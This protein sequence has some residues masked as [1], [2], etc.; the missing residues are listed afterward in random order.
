MTISSTTNRVSY[1]GDAVTVA[2]AFPY[3]FLVDADITV[4]L[5]VDSTAVETTQT[6]TT[7]YTLTGAGGASGGTVT[8][9]TAPAVGETLVILRN[10]AQTQ[11]LDLTEN[12]SL[13]AESVEQAIDRLTIIAQRLQDLMDRA[14]TLSDGSAASSLSLPTPVAGSAIG[15][16]ADE[17]T[18]VNL[19]DI[20]GTT[21]SAFGE[22]LIDDANAAAARTTLD[23]SQELDSLTALTAPALDDL[24]HLRDVSGTPANKKMA[25][26][27]ILGLTNRVGLYNLALSTGADATQLKLSGGAGAALSATNPGY[28][29]IESNTAGTLTTFRVTADITIDLTGADWGRSGYGDFTDVLLAFYVI[30][31]GSGTFKIGIGM[32]P[33]L[34]TINDTDTSI[35]AS[36]IDAHSDLL[37]NAALESGTWIC[38]RVGWFYAAYTDSGDEWAIQT[39]A[40][41]INIGKD[42]PP[43][44]SYI[45]CDEH[46]GHGAVA[47]KVRRYT[48]NAAVN[49]GTAFYT[50][51]NA[52]DGTVITVLEDGLYA[53][54]ATDKHTTA[55]QHGVALNSGASGTTALFSLTNIQWLCGTQAGA[56]L[57]DTTSGT[58]RLSA[59][60]ELRCHTDSSCTSTEARLEVTKIGY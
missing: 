3:R 7:E 51:D 17:L 50:V 26:E 48:N 22:T 40:G 28:A 38:K 27:R 46:T 6:L 57:N 1:S 20:T 13:P 23:A 49:T 45:R 42:L 29:V 39:D 36:N 44:N 34:R 58:R 35:T 24:I 43:I 41:D 14:I 18:L 55:S 47:S 33:V 25:I 32:D 4:I 37:V 8:M 19:T 60:D 2:F 5:V 12:D 53:F 30:D 52:D 21:I 15:W 16:S 59:G 54:S 10:P 56:G 31:D 9:L 11:T